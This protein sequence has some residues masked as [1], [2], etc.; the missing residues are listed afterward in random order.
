MAVTQTMVFN[1]VPPKIGT[2]SPSV[3]SSKAEA[4]WNEL[5]LT[6]IPN[7]QTA[8]TQIN[9][10]E[11]NINT[12]EAAVIAS[13]VLAQSAATEATLTSNAC[14]STA[15]N[16]GSWSVLTGSLNI[17]ASVNHNGLA[18]VLNLNIAD[19]ALSEPTA[20]NTDWTLASTPEEVDEMFS[21]LPITSIVRDANNFISSITF[22]G[23]YKY[24]TTRDVTDSLI[25]KEEF[26]D[27]DG[28]T[29]LLTIDYTR[30]VNRFVTST[31]RT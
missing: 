25:D 4:V 14:L 16:K 23:G 5:S 7:L 26:T 6:T 9:S 28:V 1:S 31:T 3:Y 20:L 12:K 21:H 13:T 24:I 17:P 2:D 11:D 22:T 18:W 29:V 8:F 15:N 27:T 10:T 30:D 19:I